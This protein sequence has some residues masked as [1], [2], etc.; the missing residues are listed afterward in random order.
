MCAEASPKENT[1]FLG[2]G[3]RDSDP[4][5]STT[6][7]TSSSARTRRGP[8]EHRAGV[9]FARTPQTEDEHPGPARAQALLGCPAQTVQRGE[10]RGRTDIGEGPERGP[11]HQHLHHP[12]AGSARR[13]ARNQLRGR[14]RNLGQ[15]NRLSLVGYWLRGGPGQCLEISIPVLQ[16]RWR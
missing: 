11:V 14:A 3:Q 5:P 12:R 6:P 9:D 15:K 8:W 16:K 7:Q 4:L 2:F 1:R 10:K 13:F